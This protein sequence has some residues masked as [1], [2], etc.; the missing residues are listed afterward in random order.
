MLS[1]EHEQH[2]R[3]LSRVTGLACVAAIIVLSLLPGDERPH[4]GASGQIEHVAAYLGTAV[5]LA[6]GFR[7]M[8][9]RVAALSAL[10]GLAAALEI[11]QRLVPGRHSQVIDWFASSMGAGIGVLAVVLIEGLRQTFLPR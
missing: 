6:L 5:L 7:T 2:L 9:N 8:R 1:R 10:V 11:M 4:T 3:R